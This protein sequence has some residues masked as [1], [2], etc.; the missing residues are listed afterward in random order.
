MLVSVEIPS[1][2]ART[3]AAVKV[4]TQWFADLPAAKRVTLDQTLYSMGRSFVS[5]YMDLM[6][7]V[8]I[9]QHGLLPEEPKILAPNPPTTLD[10]FF[11]QA[12]LS[13]PVSVLIAAAVFDKPFVGS[14][15]RAT[16]HIPATRS[17]RGA[18]VE[19]IIRQVKA[20]RS[21]VIFPE[22]ALSPLGC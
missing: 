22:G 6:L 3:G 7:D 12:L 16:G 10:P 11:I 21:V 17:S 5:T 8:D 2:V 14:Y 13:E 19:T 4:L 18:T 20:G 1:I 9:Q 15:L